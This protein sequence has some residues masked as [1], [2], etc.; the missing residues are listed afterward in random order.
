MARREKSDTV[1]RRASEGIPQ[2]PVASLRQVNGHK[3]HKKTQKMKRHQ[4]PWFF[5]C[6]FVLFVAFLR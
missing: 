2:H 1:A 6:L 3:K 5:L 4:T